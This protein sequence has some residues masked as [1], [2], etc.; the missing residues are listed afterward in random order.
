[1]KEDEEE[2]EER[3]ELEFG[4]WF[5]SISCSLFKQ[6]ASANTFVASNTSEGGR[7]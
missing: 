1:M 7:V 4:G 2:R 3:G 5:P 6:V